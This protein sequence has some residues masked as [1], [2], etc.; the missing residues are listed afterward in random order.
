MVI[1]WSVFLAAG[2]VGCACAHGK[3][4]KRLGK[5]ELIFS[6]AAGGIMLVAGIWWLTLAS[7]EGDV[8]GTILSMPVIAAG[9]YICHGAARE[10]RKPACMTRAKEVQDEKGRIC[11]HGSLSARPRSFRGKNRKHA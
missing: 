8:T 11:A 4:A 2:A 9:L 5:P 1:F 10:M 3:Y 7:L 6:Y